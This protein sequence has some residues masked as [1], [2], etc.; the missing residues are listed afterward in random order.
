MDENDLK[1]KNIIIFEKSA[2]MR[3]KLR[4][5]FEHMN[6]SFQVDFR[7]HS[8]IDNFAPDAHD[9][10][11]VLVTKGEEANANN[12]F[13]KIEKPMKIGQL[14]DHI[15]HQI[16]NLAQEHVISI[17]HYQLDLEQN[18][19]LDDDEQIIRL[20]DI[21]TRILKHLYSSG[22]VFTPRQEL[23]EAIWGYGENIETHTLETHIYRL[24]Q[25]IESDSSD[26]K[27][28]MTDDKGYYLAQRAD[29]NG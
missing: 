22:P 18:H 12:T 17:G 26:P 10:P 4:D 25:K 8:E 3:D 28:V 9:I 7:D 23:L 20:T 6:P 16:K 27:I 1:Q 13:K 11:F 5:A 29:K 15:V 21:E 2:L 19:L 14:F 24:R